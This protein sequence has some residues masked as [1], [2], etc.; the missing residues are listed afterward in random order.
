[1]PFLH[2]Q[3]KKQCACLRRSAPRSLA[4][5]NIG[6]H[7]GAIHAQRSRKRTIRIVGNVCA[8]LLA[9]NGISAE[10]PIGG[11]GRRRILQRLPV[12]ESVNDVGAVRNTLA[13][14]GD[15]YGS[16]G[17]AAYVRFLVA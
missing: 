15:G 4:L 2:R 9:R 10:G 3:A 8:Y 13:P 5:R 14:T 16:G 1:M 12:Q 6:I 11:R 7:V 17:S